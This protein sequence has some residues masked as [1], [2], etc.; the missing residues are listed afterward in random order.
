MTHCLDCGSERASDQ[1][2]VC[3][4]TS[5]AAELVFRRRLIRQMTVF[6]AGSLLFPYV[7]QIYPPLDLDGMLVFFGV[8]FFVAL[9]LA[10]V[11]ESRAR[12]RKELEVLRHLFSGLIPIP[13]IL[14]AALV[15]NGR[16]DSP[17]N[18][19]FHAAVVDS[20]YQMKGVVRGTR[21]LFVPSWRAGHRFERLAVDSDDYDRFRP[22]DAVN[23]GVAPGALGIP[24]F[25]G[26]Y[27][28]SDQ[29]TGRPGQ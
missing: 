28:R 5:A 25:Y 7:S 2:P 11:L 10:I 14:L 24:W 17:K 27:R 12:A 23:V 9:A 20:R 21:R 26:V 4:L 13:F 22:G 8:V 18:I 19:T 16:L 15:L 3:G 6:L 1:C 29:F